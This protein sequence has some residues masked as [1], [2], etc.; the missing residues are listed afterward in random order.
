VV[1]LGNEVGINC[2]KLSR[3]NHKKDYPKSI[4]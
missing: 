3:D 4:V 1:K 2:L